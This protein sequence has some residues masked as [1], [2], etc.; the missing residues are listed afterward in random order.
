MWWMHLHRPRR[1]LHVDPEREECRMRTGRLY[2]SVLLM[3]FHPFALMTSAH[4]PRRIRDERDR[5]RPEL[6]RGDGQ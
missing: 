4:L 5:L 2:R 6:I 3:P 1:G